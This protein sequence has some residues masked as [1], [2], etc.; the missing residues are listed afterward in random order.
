MSRPQAIPRVQIDNERMRVTEWRFPPGA[1]TGWHKHE[2]DYCI[3]PV[4][5]GV[6]EIDAADGRR[7]ARL[8]TGE[9]Y[10]RPAGVEHDVINANDFE[11]V[12]IEVEVK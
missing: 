12:F 4:T 5:T 11:F 8:I 7:D 3:V 1:A 6:L 2:Y 9:S 10:F